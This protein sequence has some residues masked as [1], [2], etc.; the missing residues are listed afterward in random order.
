M[1]FGDCRRPWLRGVA[2]SDL[3]ELIGLWQ[4]RAA[5]LDYWGDK[6]AA[7]QLRRCVDELAAAA[8]RRATGNT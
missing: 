4:S 3:W 2:R 7:D 1:L 6:K 8:S 5:H